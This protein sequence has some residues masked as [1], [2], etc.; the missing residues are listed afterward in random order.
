MN[1]NEII[2]IKNSLSNSIENLESLKKEL[3]NLKLNQ[4][5]IIKSNKSITPGTATKISYDLKGLIVKGDKLQPEDIPELPIDKIQGL[6]KFLSKKL[7]SSDIKDLKPIKENLHKI[8]AGTGIKINYNENGLVVSSASLL[9]N[10]IPSISM[11]KINGLKNKLDYLENIIS[12][13]SF[14]SENNLGNLNLT[15]EAKNSHEIIA[16]IPEELTERYT[17]ATLDTRVG[18]L[19]KDKNLFATKEMFNIL[20]DALKNINLE[21]TKVIENKNL[22]ISDIEGLELILRKKANQ[23]DLIELSNTVSSLISSGQSTEYNEL[24][25]ELGKKANIEEL[26]DISNQF[27]NVKNIMNTLVE[28]LPSELIL[29]ELQTIKTEISNINGRLSV[30]EQN[31]IPIGIN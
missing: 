18:Q 21:Q 29:E 12:N 23:V 16:N 9:E 7:E 15:S 24:K 20:T 4:D 31:I 1:V 8:K 26:K 17:I 28:K 14:I 11:E 10:D 13:K 6:E 22:E 19:E 25:N 30:L 2:E 3:A 27:D 5:S